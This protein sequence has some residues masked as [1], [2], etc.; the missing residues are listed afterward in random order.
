MNRGLNGGALVLP[1]LYGGSGERNPPDHAVPVR[2]DDFGGPGK[3]ELI[4]AKTGYNVTLHDNMGDMLEN[5][6]EAST[7]RYSVAPTIP[8]LRR[9][10][11]SSSKV[12]VS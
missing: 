9:A 7:V 4:A 12:S 11:R 10:S 1:S 3:Y 2:A 5:P 6:K 8:N